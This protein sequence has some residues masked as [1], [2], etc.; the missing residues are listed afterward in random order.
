[1]CIHGVAGLERHLHDRTRC[2]RQV[3]THTPFLSG[4]PMNNS[5]LHPLVRASLAGFIFNDEL[6]LS[7][8][9]HD[10]NVS[11][12]DSPP[13][14]E[15]RAPQLRAPQPPRIVSPS[16][17]IAFASA[18]ACYASLV[19]PCC[20]RA[21]ELSFHWRIA[22]PAKKSRRRPRRAATPTDATEPLPTDE[23][24]CIVCQHFP[25]EVRPALG[26]LKA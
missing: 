24:L 7:L 4:A 14:E 11:Y 8:A 19:S 16:L 26:T 10:V 18:L 21:C 1:V 9:V 20:R 6:T 15:P 22:P 12:N 23:D 5:G 17:F 25:V 2:R 3:V 13:A